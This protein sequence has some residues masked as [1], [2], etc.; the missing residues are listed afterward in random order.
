MGDQ[1]NEGQPDLL[2][3]LTFNRRWLEVLG[4]TTG[5]RVEVITGPGQLIIRLAT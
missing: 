4:F 2:P 5:Q 3:Q 1:L